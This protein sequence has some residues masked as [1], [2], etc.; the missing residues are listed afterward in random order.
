M[1]YSCK[2]ISQKISEKKMGNRGSKSVV[3]KNAIVKEQRVYGSW[4]IKSM[5]L[6]CALTGFERNY[7]VKILSNQINKRNS[8]SSSAI[9]SQINSNLLN[10]NFVTGFI[11]A[12][13]CFIITILRNPRSGAS[14]K[15]GWKVQA[16]FTI[17]LHKKDMAL[18][19]LIKSYFGGRGNISKE[20][21]N[22]IKYEITSIQDLINVI[23]PHFEKFPL[24]TQKKADFILWKQAIELMQNKE[25]LRIEGLRQIVALKASLNLGL[26][27]ELKE[28]FP[29][30]VPIGRSSLQDEKILNSYWLAGFVSGEG[31]FIIS[32]F[33]TTTKLGETVKITFSLTQH[34]RD[35][36]LMN[37]LI[38]YFGAGN[39]CKYREAIE[40]RISKTK[41]LNDKVIPFFEE[42]KILGVKSQD[43]D[44][45]KQV[46]R[47]ISNGDH[48]TVEGLEKI[49]KIKANMNTGR[50]IE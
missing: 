27:V 26:S 2:V 47:L 22:I 38:E 20:Y 48:L 15:I 13:G 7:Q 31:C 10:A 25:H 32:I 44:D 36:Q 19:G 35:E 40:F 29:G 4:C 34:T 41:D 37:S 14:T 43:Y 46:A 24:K 6:R 42:Y 12:E 3:C 39:V 18:M 28:A 49:R 50:K 1:N 17:S 23:I 8:Y 45:F 16:R 9:Q 21:K 11:D 5:H 30:I 33:K